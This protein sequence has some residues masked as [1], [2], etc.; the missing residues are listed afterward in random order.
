MA[1]A[2]SEPMRT[3]AGA[4]M[5]RGDAAL[6]FKDIVRSFD[7]FAAITIPPAIAA[8]ELS[9]AVTTGAQWK[10]GCPTKVVVV[11]T[12]YTWKLFTPGIS[13]LANLSGGRR[14]LTSGAA[15]RNEPFPPTGAC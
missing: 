13:K 3:A 4:S 8:G 1:Q 12:Y 6:P 2:P 14:L 10:P 7:T 15:F 9:P 11:R 5:L